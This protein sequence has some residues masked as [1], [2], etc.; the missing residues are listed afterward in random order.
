[1]ASNPSLILASQSP[2]R[3]QQLENFGFKFTAA[4]PTVDEDQLKKEGPA[5]LTELTRFLSE[6]KARSL[7]SQFPG[8][9]ILGSDQL[10]ELDGERLDKP[11]SEPKAHAQLTLMAGREHRLIT[12]LA[13]VRDSQIHLFT[14][15]TRIRLKEL[16]S[17]MI[18][19]YLK[20]DRP[21][22]CAGSYKIEK[23]GMSLVESIDS[24]DPS[25]IQG[26]PMLSLMRGLEK[27]KI[28]VADLW[29]QA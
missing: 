10:V 26:L 3:R 28:N 18:S 29:E 12:S 16:S 21:F 25:A 11:G 24:Q 8:A 6:K 5:D 4:S 14:D 13:M 22:D 27:Y 7:Q 23:A 15:V 19:A 9:L 17:R 2:Y 1:M 20:T